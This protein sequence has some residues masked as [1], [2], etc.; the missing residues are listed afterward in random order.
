[1][2]G[3]HYSEETGMDKDGSIKHWIVRTSP[4]RDESGKIVAAMEMNLDISERKQLEEKLASCLKRSIM[5]SSTISP[6]RCL[7]WKSAAWK[8]WTAT[9][10]YRAVYG[11]ATRPVDRYL[12]SG[13]YLNPVN[14]KPWP[15][16]W[17][18]RRR[19]QSGSPGWG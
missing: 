7:Y 15:F 9:K 19:I 11:L 14:A 6:T 4:I 1:M 2:A 3:P 16:A 17:P 8:F 10:A 18:R 13:V 5:P 12:F